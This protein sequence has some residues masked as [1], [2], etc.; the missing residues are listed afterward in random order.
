MNE[1]YRKEG[2]AHEKKQKKDK[3][4]RRSIVKQK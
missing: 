2:L 1:M 3:V 4:D